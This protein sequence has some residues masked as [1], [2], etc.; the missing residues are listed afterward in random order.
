MQHIALIMDGNRRWARNNKLQTVVMGHK[1]GVEPVKKSVQW[2]LDHNIKYL[3]LY[4]FSLENRGRSEEEKSGIFS[5]M[6]DAIESESNELT[7]KGVSIRFIGD[8]TLFPDFLRE[9][10]EYIESQTSAG[11]KLHLQVMFF[12]GGQQEIVAATRALAQKVKEGKISPDDINLESIE[13]SLWTAGI[14]DPE[15]IIRAG[16][17]S[18]LSNFLPFQSAYS[19]LFFLDVL[20]PDFNES[21]LNDCVE[22]F[23]VI[24]RKFGQ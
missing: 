1:K 11:T 4:A 24:K 8:R 13:K 12:Y 23:N 9:K 17:F 7:Q 14:P 18:R 5:V 22:R 20:W 3:S 10:I 19:E 15:I 16:G 2:S 21:H 6:I